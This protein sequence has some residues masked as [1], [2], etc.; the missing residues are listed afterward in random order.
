MKAIVDQDTCIGCELCPEVCPAVFRMAGDK[1]EA[2]VDPV[3]A[4]AEECAR[5]AAD[6]CPVAAIAVEE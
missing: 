5:D 3:P 6:Q 1:A 2:Y 4:D